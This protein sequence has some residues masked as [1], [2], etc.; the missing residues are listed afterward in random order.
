MVLFLTKRLNFTNL[1]HM[2][3]AKGTCDRLLGSI[4]KGNCLIFCFFLLTSVVI[5]SQRF[6]KW[7]FKTEG[8]IFGTP[9]IDG[10]HIYIGSGDHKL[11]ALEK[12][13]GKKIWEFE[14]SQ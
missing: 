12:E 1:N 3:I 5:H 7:E 9:L 8:E 13:T 6:V 11:Y 4:F 2:S 10:D 14:N